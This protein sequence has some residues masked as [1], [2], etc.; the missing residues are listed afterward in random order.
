M[1]IG[2]D[3]ARHERRIF[4]FTHA[5]GEIDAFGDLVNDSFSDE[6][7]DADIGVF[8]LEGNDDWCQ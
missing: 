8:P 6:D 7:L 3:P 1:P 2:Q 5:K 4:Q